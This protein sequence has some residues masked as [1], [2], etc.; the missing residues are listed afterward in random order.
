MQQARRPTV[1]I[2][3]DDGVTR[4]ILRQILKQGDY[5]VI[6]EASDGEAAVAMCADHLPDIV[7]LDVMMPKLDGIGA[8]KAIMASNPQ[9]IVLMITMDAAA[10]TVNEALAHGACGYVLKPF[11]VGKILDTL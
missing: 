7:C 8:L 4:A 5:E 11:N 2:A 1:L 6:G 3:E 10:A 9:T